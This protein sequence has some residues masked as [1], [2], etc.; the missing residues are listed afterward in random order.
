[1]GYLCHHFTFPYSESLAI[2][3]THSQG[4]G[5]FFVYDADEPVTLT[6]KA[7]HTPLLEEGGFLLSGCYLANERFF[8]F[9]VGA[10]DKKGGDYLLRAKEASTA[11][12]DAGHCFWLCPVSF[13][14]WETG[15]G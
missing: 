6:T 7:N 8:I 13:V 1:L 14:V 11:D 12:E 10:L 4:R 5:R 2:S 3:N 15:L 9:F